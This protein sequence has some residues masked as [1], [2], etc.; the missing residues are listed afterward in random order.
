MEAKVDIKLYYCEIDAL[1]LNHWLQ[2]L[3]A[4]FSVYH[5]GEEHRISFDGLK[6]KGHVLSWW[7]S[8]T[9]TLRL[10]ED[11]PVTKWGG[12]QN[13][14][15]VTILPYRVCRGPVDLVALLQVEANSECTR[16]HHRA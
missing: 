6:L 9:K 2:Q 4:Y 8:H 3:E 13:L 12:F 16:A 1:K 5:I 7:E 11:P 15:K 14:H 10:G